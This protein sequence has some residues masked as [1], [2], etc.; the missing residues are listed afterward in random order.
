MLARFEVLAQSFKW[1]E[2]TPNEK[3]KNELRANF[4]DKNSFYQK[5]QGFAFE[6]L[7]LSKQSIDSLTDIEHT[8]LKQL[9]EDKTIIISKA[10]KGNAVVIQDINDYRVKIVELLNQDGKF[11]KLDNNV[12]MDREKCLQNYLRNLKNKEVNGKPRPQRLSEVDYHRILPSGSRAGVMYGLPKIHKKNVPIRPIISSIGTYN[13]KL[14]KFLV[15]ILT[16]LLENNQI[17]LKDTFDFVNKISQLDT[18]IDVVMLS[19]DVES[20]FTNIP[21]LETIDII[22]N[23]IYVKAKKYFHGLTKEELKKLLI[24]CTQQSHFQFNGQY[25]DQVD[26]VSMGSPLGPLF[27]NIFMADFEK[28]NIAQLKQ[29]GVNLWY[30]YVDD[31]FATLTRNSKKEEEILSFLNKC[32]PNIR[33]TIE[34]EDKNRLPFLD[35]CVVRNINKYVTTLY[36]KKTFTGVYLNWTSLT[37]KKYKVGLVRCLLDRIW[38]ICTTQED[39]NEEVKKLKSI[40]AKN[41][42]PANIVNEIIRK[43]I[44]KKENGIISAATNI[45]EDQKI[46]RFIVLPFVNRKADDYAKRLKKLVSDNFQQVD[47]NVAFKSPRTIGDL[48]PYKDQTKNKTDQSLV[49][50]KINCITCGAEY[51]GKTER[52]L[53]YRLKEHQ[54]DK[55]SACHDHITKNPTHQMDYVNVEIIDRASSDFKLRMKELLCILAR[56][57]ELNKQLNSQSKFEVNTILITKYQQHQ[58]TKK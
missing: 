32:H 11:S 28:K 53:K 46:T 47:F 25:Y 1:L 16:P 17:I 44:E 54:N 50:Y 37:A 10:D 29:L 19:F 22:L 2:L 30:R 7:E 56:K 27:A 4:D 18:E 13:Y 21:T 34:K 35:T 23:Q 48:F 38:R 39:R 9:A 41:Q 45:L 51:I 6:F 12:T 15:E 8:A 55:K 14:A 24:V 3:S 42:Y 49:V 33:F 20:L 52:I 40:L 5:L 36:H 31:I 43:Y 58:Q 26:G 57:P